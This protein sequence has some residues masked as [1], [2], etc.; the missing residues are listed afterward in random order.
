MGYRL[1]GD[2][3][4][5]QRGAHVSRA[6]AVGRYPVS[7]PFQGDDLGKPLERMLGG[8]VSGL[9]WGGTHSMHR[10]NVDNA[11]PVAGVHAGEYPASEPEGSLGQPAR[12]RPANTTRPTSDQRSST[13]KIKP[14]RPGQPARLWGHPLTI[15]WQSRVRAAHVA[16]RRPA[17]YQPAGTRASL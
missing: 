17:G 5:H 4:F 13:R 12:T 9:V 11:A 6:H 15:A 3:V 8:H 10:R 16:S 14:V 1:G 2:L 7:G